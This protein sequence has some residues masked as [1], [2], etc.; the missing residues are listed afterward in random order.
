MG[1]CPG[2]GLQSLAI[3]GDDPGEGGGRDGVVVDDVF[4]NGF[5]YETVCNW[6]ST[7]ISISEGF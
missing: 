5:F 1:V 4:F 2:K 3:T 6:F 7:L